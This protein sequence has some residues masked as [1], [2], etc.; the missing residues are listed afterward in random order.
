[1]RV[2]LDENMPR[3]IGRLLTEHEVSFAELENWKGKENGELLALVGQKFDVFVTSDRNLP[4]QQNLAGR[5]LSLIVLPTN[6]LALL[7][8]NLLALQGTLD[9]LA[10][11][12]FPALIVIDWTGRRSMRRLDGDSDAFSELQP[13]PAYTSDT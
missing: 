5:E 7:H 6:R 3:Q 1:M 8:A 4:F 2:F 10:T 12:N 13:V 11:Y 9:E